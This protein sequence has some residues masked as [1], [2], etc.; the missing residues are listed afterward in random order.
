AGSGALV[1]LEG[2]Q[3]VPPEHLVYM[4]AA[5]VLV[6]GGYVTNVMSMRVGEVSAVAPFRYTVLLWAILVGFVVFAEL[7]DAPTLVGAGIVV[8]AG[9]YTLWREQRLGQ[10]AAATASTRPF[11]G[12]ARGGR[13]QR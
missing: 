4:I 3:P 2:W 7:P 8:A 9:L 11:G 10:S 5:G 12:G 6:V 1:P 13:R